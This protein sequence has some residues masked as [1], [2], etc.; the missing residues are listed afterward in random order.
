[1]IGKASGGR[2]RP[3]GGRDDRWPGPPVGRV[4]EGRAIIAGN[5]EIGSPDRGPISSGPI[6]L[7]PARYGAIATSCQHRRPAV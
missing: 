7:G 4:T 3:G 5:Q 1:M 2:R 6:A